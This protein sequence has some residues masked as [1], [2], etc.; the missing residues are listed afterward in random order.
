MAAAAMGREAA[1]SPPAR[2]VRFPSCR[3]S[4]SVRKR[5]RLAALYFWAERQ[6]FAASLTTPPGG[7]LIDQA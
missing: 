4:A 6:G 1:R 3:N 7:D 2:R 5:S